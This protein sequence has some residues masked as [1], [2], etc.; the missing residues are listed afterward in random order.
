MNHPNFAMR[1]AVIF[2]CLVAFIFTGFG[3]RIASAQ[4][5]YGSIVGT[6]TDQTGAVVPQTTVRVTNTSTGLFRE[7]TS[8]SAGY[9]S[10]SNLPPGTYDLTT[11]ASGFKPLTQKSVDVLI[12]SVTHSDV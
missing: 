10:M 8:D 4:V 6:V 3:G 5:L 12:N 1:R 11:S 9:Y 2:S 7:T